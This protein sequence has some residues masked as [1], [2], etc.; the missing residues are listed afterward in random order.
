MC[1]NERVKEIP[2]GL[3]EEVTAR[4]VE[5]FDPEALYLFGS[6][7][8]GKPTEDSDLDLFVVLSKS[9]ESPAKRGKRAH[10]SL[11]GVR[12]PVDILVRT[13]REAE[14][15]GWRLARARARGRRAAPR[16]SRVARSRRCAGRGRAAHHGR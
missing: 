8:W 14:R 11:W 6:H 16:A 13:R 2:A 4:L 5:E 7:A 12:A 15:P 9:D 1:H 3:L 10:L